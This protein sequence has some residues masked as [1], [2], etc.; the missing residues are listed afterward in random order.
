MLNEVKT[1]E[2]RKEELTKDKYDEIVDMAVEEYAKKKQMA[3]D[4]KE[5]LVEALKDK[6][7]EL[8]EDYEKVAG[9][10]EKTH[11]K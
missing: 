8:Q 3:M 10:G 5:T 11:K 9:D 2:E 7:D 4:A 6:W 1:L